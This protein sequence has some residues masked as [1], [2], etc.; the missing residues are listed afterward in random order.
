MSL[1]KKFFLLAFFIPIG[2]VATQDP[3]EKLFEGKEGCLLVKDLKSG[4]TVRE[5]HSKFCSER[6]YACSTFKVP[7]AAMAFDHGELVDETTT[8]KW[9]GKPQ[10][11]DTWQK[12][13][14]AR[15]W[16]ENSVV[17]Y[18]QRLTPMLGLSRVQDYLRNFKYGNQDFSGGLEEA[19]LSSTLKISAEEQVNFLRAL[20][21]EELSISKKAAQQ[22][23]SILPVGLEHRDWRIVGKTGSCFTWLDP[24]APPSERSRIGWYVGYVSHGEKEEVFAVVFKEESEKD[25]YEYAGPDAKK[26]AIQALKP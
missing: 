3:A 26:I 14:N 4:A 6:F 1:F 23:L 13:H 7:L 12:D 22:T 2:A 19:W 10:P 21:L 17:W 15:T 5:V 9:D 8:F 24:K 25:K 18:S 16:M 20:K 11:I